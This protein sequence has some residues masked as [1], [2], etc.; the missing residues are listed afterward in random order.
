VQT[1]PDG[2]GR[3]DEMRIAGADDPAHPG[4]SRRPDTTPRP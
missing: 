4:S 1:L 2:H 3:P